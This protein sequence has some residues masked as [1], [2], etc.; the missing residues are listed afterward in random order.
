MTEHEM[1]VELVR[2][3]NLNKRQYPFLELFF[4]VANE[5]KRDPRR[6]HGEGYLAGLPDY[7]LPFG[8]RVQGVYYRGFWLEIKAI[9]KKPTKKQLT[10]MALLKTWD[11][12]AG[13][14][15]SLQQAM[16]WLKQ[17]CRGVPYTWDE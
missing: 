17:Y 5:G 13:W 8:S 15:D 3:A 6:V 4:H 11:H 10:T 1:C 16:N 12:W 2:W 9:G 14:T 7:C